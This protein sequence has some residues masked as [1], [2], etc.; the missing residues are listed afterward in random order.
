MT[1]THFNVAVEMAE[2][3]AMLNR[4]G[5]AGTDDLMPRL[6]EYL[7]KSTQGRFK[8][9]KAPDGAPWAKL[10]PTYA[11]RKKYNQNK[12]LTLRGYLRSGIRYQVTGP[13]EVEVGTNAVQ[14]AIH[15]FGG[16]I[17]HKARTAK[18]RFRTDAKGELLR[19]G[20]MNGSALIFAAR[21]H[22]RA[23]ERQVDIPAHQVTIEARPFL[24]IS[25]EDSKQIQEIAQDWF[26]KRSK[27]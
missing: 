4:L 15:Q 9:Q 7:L 8:D 14:G 23:A 26:V 5:K 12:I 2:V 24:G 27:G 21:R 11:K 20:L 13:A 1:G 3:R 6:G 19:S 22:K 16:T 25:A 10:S 18:V 17:A